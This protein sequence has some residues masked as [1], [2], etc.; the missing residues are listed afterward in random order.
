L[1]VANRGSE[2]MLLDADLHGFAAFAIGEHRLAAPGARMPGA[3]T[4]APK[5]ECSRLGW[6]LPARSYGMVRLTKRPD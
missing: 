5:I 6:A 2:S 1:F 3:R 4:V